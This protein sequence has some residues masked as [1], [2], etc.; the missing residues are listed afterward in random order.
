MNQENSSTSPRLQW[1]TA[2]EW[3]A[4]RRSEAKFSLVFT[5]GGATVLGLEVSPQVIA[6]L[7]QFL[8][9][10]ADSN[11]SHVSSQNPQVAAFI[12]LLVKHQLLL[13]ESEATQGVRLNLY[14]DQHTL[15]DTWLLPAERCLTV[16]I[17]LGDE[18]RLARLF[19]EF[20]RSRPAEHM[21]SFLKFYQDMIEAGPVRFAYERA[22]PTTR[23]PIP[24][25]YP[26][27]PRR[28][29]EHRAAIQVFYA[30][31][32]ASTKWHSLTTKGSRLNIAWEESK[33][34]YQFQ[35]S[36]MP[37]L[38]EAVPFFHWRA[39]VEGESGAGGVGQT[40]A[41]AEYSAM[42][43]AWERYCLS[44]PD[45]HASPRQEGAEEL[46]HFPGIYFDYLRRLAKPMLHG[47]DF[48]EGWKLNNQQAVRLP[49]AWVYFN[50]HNSVANSN[51]AAFGSSL[52][53]AIHGGKIEVIERHLLMQTYLQRQKSQ[54]FLL[55]PSLIPASIQEFLHKAGRRARF[56]NLGRLNDIQAVVCMLA[57]DRPPYVSIGCSGKSN[58][59]EAALKALYE[60]IVTDSQWSRRIE[61]YGVK[62][63]V[64]MGHGYLQA[65]PSKVSFEE[66]AWYWA[67]V[68]NA[69]MLLHQRFHTGEP[70][71]GSL[72][73][74]SFVVVDLGQ[75]IVPRGAVVK[76]IHPEALPLPS[77]F[78]HAKALFELL[79]L[80]ETL[81]IPMF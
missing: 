81:T 20:A 55:A 1:N 29:Q 27:W 2:V 15:I 65:D 64:E 3:T 5:R 37:Q 23:T 52:Q 77:C 53:D 69:E 57:R 72:C 78:A 39:Q 36:P 9:D 59:E 71:V 44:R 4:Q 16:D 51:G 33:A 25:H 48:C 41:A 54:E 28:L 22:M 30:E 66:S 74:D 13:E 17:L 40:I 10:L 49:T 68:E 45:L 21:V 47:K 58:L 56:Y 80:D 35:S 38:S 11:Q 8:P 18:A 46:S 43:E 42:C 7:E 61:Q 62:R 6:F 31:A 34:P 14:L 24:Q 19:D 63:F 32:V 60:A 50:G 76:V 70:T 75:N 26:A 12:R 79:Q 67:S 73:E